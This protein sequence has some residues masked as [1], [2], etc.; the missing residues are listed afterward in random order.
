[1]KKR[2]GELFSAFDGETT[3]ERLDNYVLGLMVENNPDSLT[4]R[5]LFIMSFIIER[6]QSCNFGKDNGYLEEL[7]LSILDAIGDID[8]PVRLLKA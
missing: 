6:M 7:R 3:T 5:E 2:F 1:M 4:P 8:K